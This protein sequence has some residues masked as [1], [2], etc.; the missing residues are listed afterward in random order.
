M[1][2]KFS[3]FNLKNSK[4]LLTLRLSERHR[5]CNALFLDGKGQYGRFCFRRFIHCCPWNLRSVVSSFTLQ[6]FFLLLHSPLTLG[7][8]FLLYFLDMPL[9]QFPS[10]TIT[11]FSAAVAR[12]FLSL[13]MFGPTV[14]IH[15]RTSFLGDGVFLSVHC[16]VFSVSIQYPLQI[17]L[18]QSEGF[19]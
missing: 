16:K 1:E 8:S 19:S 18:R 5:T 17:D 9:N 11:T 4:V 12:C 7:G 14:A 2:R 10:S 3:F 15:F 13:R 6:L